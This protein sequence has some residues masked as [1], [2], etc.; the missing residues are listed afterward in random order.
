MPQQQQQQ[1]CV[2]F[3]QWSMAGSEAREEDRARSVG[4]GRAVLG[5]GEPAKHLSCP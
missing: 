4:S 2:G 3:Q 5:P 1:I